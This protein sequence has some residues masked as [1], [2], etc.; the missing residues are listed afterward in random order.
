[1]DDNKQKTEVH[2][3]S[4][5]EAWHGPLPPPESLKQYDAIVPGAAERIL[6][7]AEKE[8]EHRHQ[9][10]NRT[11]KYN[12]RLIIVSTILAFLCVILLGGIL[13]FAIYVKSDTGAIATAIG[14][15]AAV[16]GL[17]TY[18]KSKHSN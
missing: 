13:C 5:M 15:I 9:R 2:Q 11:L 8:M 17:F 4:Q 16:V 14:A 10:E 3:V 18:S 6:L 12:G 7:M 1:M